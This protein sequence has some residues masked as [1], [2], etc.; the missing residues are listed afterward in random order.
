LRSLQGGKTKMSKKLYVGNLSFQASAESV[1]ELFAPFG[2]VQDVSLVTDRYTGRSRG[3]AFVE[4]TSEEAA[5]KAR[6]ALNGKPFQDRNL[7]V[8]WA[9]PEGSRP[10][11]GGRRDRDRGSRQPFRRY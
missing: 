8:D 6:E 1:K 2:E 5:T 3:F 10:S 4:M 9:R 11:G 7:T